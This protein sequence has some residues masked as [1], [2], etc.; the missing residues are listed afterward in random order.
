MAVRVSQTIEEIPE[1]EWAR[2][3]PP[4][5]PFADYQ[6]FVSLEKSSSVGPRTGWLPFYLTTSD[7]Q[8]LLAALVIYAKNN[9]YGEYIFDFAWAQAFANS[10]LRYYPKLVSAIPFTPAT[11]PKLLFRA[12]LSDAAASNARDV[13]ASDLLRAARDLSSQMGASSIHAL[14]LSPAELQYFEDDK[15]FLRHSFQYHWQNNHYVSFENFLSAL[16]SKRRKEVLR[17]RRQVA[18]TGVSIERLTGS[19]ILPEHADLMYE[20]YLSTL[21]KMGGHDYLTLDFFRRIFATMRDKILFVVAS[22]PSGRIVA[23]ALNY[24]GNDTLFGRNWGCIAEYR[25]LHFELCYYQGIEFAIERGFKLFEAGAQG[26]HKFTR[27]FLPQLTYSA[28][29][30]DHPMLDRAIRNF[31]D[32]EKKEI[33]S[34]FKTYEEHTPYVDHPVIKPGAPTI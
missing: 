12:D 6:F 4:A 3:A 11:G 20:F 22:E 14:F 16:T 28:H 8:G 13:A 2:I 10:G 21:D 34:L 25:G 30:I 7:E 23:G 9:S 24:F 31:V 32:R 5:F 19:Q 18:S 27:G 1:L 15:L 29:S 26:E 33:A 17:E